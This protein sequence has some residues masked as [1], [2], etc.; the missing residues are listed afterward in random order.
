MEDRHEVIEGGEVATESAPG[1]LSL[2]EKA[3]IYT[4]AVWRT[5][6]R[7]S[8]YIHAVIY[9]GVMLL[10]MFINLA[11]SSTLWFFWPLGGWGAGLVIH[12]LAIVKLLPKYEAMK[13]REIV[14]Q[15]EIRQGH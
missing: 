2:E 12:W 1:G 10:L 7:F 15:L 4:T 9:V 11:T 5:R 6:L 8:L 14:H 3:R 13:E